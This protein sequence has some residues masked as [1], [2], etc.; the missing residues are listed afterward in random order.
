[1]KYIKRITQIALVCLFAMVSTTDTLAGDLYKETPGG[2]KYQ[3][4][5]KSKSGKAAVV[6][7]ILFLNLS[8]YLHGKKDSLLFD[9]RNIPAGQISL[10][11][12]NPSFKTDIMEIFAMMELQDSVSFILP[13]DSFFIKTAGL[14]ELP[15]HIP[16]G[17]SLLFHAGLKDIKTVEEMEA[18]Q[19]E[20]EAA[21]KAEAEAQKGMEES[22]LK[23]Y[24]KSKNITQTPTASGLVIVLQK[25][26]NGT[27][28]QKGQTVTVHYTGYLLN[29]TKFDSSVDRGQPFEF[30][31]GEGQV[32]RGWDEGVAAMEIGSSFQLIIPSE[33]GY[34][35]NGA[36]G[37]IPPYSPLVFDVEL[38]KAE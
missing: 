19:K 12:Q 26:G 38:I 8:Y 7:N 5:R 24:L 10:Q 4:L 13:A 16:K 15:P 27:K 34:G 25:A 14:K 33:L 37:S 3:F 17:A 29:G 9:S 35:G 30:K 23:A 28:P 20:A 31:I 36:G 18:I 22:K 2:I 21:Q 32:I 1:M 6:S 11:L